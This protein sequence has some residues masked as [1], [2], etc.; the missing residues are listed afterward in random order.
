M[1]N[2]Y[3]SMLHEEDHWLSQILHAVSGDGCRHDVCVDHPADRLPAGPG[4]D[5]IGV[6]GADVGLWGQ[7][8]THVAQHYKHHWYRH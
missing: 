5:D 1:T 7:P 3:L 6:D 8:F 2:T 4:V